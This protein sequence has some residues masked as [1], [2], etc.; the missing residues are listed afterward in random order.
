MYARAHALKERWLS[1]EKEPK[2]RVTL[3]VKCGGCVCRRKP[4]KGKEEELLPR[5][6]S[7]RASVACSAHRADREGNSASGKHRCCRG[8]FFPRCCSLHPSLA[9]VQVDWSVTSRS[10]VLVP[11]LLGS[12]PVVTTSIILLTVLLERA[13]VGKHHSWA[14]TSFSTATATVTLSSA[15]LCPVTAPE[16]NSGSSPFT[17]TTTARS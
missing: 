12:L 15:Y 13:Q 5:S 4:G 3:P 11:T 7:C 8:S 2:L 6:S 9:V 10:W 1:S 17:A 14:V 16:S